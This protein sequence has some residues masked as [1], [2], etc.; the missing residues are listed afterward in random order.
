[1]SGEQHEPYATRPSL[2]LR[3]RDPQDGEAWGVFVETYTPLVYEYCRRRGLQASDVADVTQEVM[4]QVMRSISSFCYDPERGRFR[5]WLG[6]VA[7]T[8]LLRFFRNGARAVTFAGGAVDELMMQVEDPESDT[9]W[10]EGF[11]ARVLEVA[12]KRARP[13]FEERT[14]TLFEGSWIRGASASN[15]AEEF[16]VTVDLVY[17]A[18]SRVLKRLREE[19]ATIAEDYPLLLASRG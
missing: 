12:M 5:D 14:W 2:L 7:R 19:V 11:H 13:D 9:L 16:G 1:M 10:T 18:R 3:L 8:K 17:V 4:T 15:L 6:T